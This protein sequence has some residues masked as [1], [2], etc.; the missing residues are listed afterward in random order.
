[1]SNL[2]HALQYA[3]IGLSVIPIS[4]ENKRPLVKWR[5]YQEEQASESQIEEWWTQWPTADVGV[6]TGAVSGIVAVDCDTE[7]AYKEVT[8]RGI[9]SVVGATTKRG[10]HLLFR[11]PG[12]TVR[13]TT[14]WD[15]MENVDVRGDGGYIKVYPSTGYNWSLP[16][17]VDI[18][19][20]MSEMPVWAYGETGRREEI[21]F[22]D[23]ER[24]PIPNEIGAGER[25]DAI[26]RITGAIIKE[27]DDKWGKDILHLVWEE[28]QKRC[29]PPLTK[30]EVITIVRSVSAL[31]K[32]N[33]PNEFNAKGERIKAVRSE[34]EARIEDNRDM[35]TMFNLVS[36]FEMEPR[37][38]TYLV[39]DLIPLGLP[40]VLASPGGVGKTFMLMDLAMKVSLM[41]EEDAPTW[42][43]HRIRKHG[44]SVLFLGEDDALE[45]SRRM[46]SLDPSHRRLFMGEGMTIISIPELPHALTFGVKKYDALE[47]TPEAHAWRE[48]LTSELPEVILG[49]R[50]LALVVIDPLQSFFD[51]RFDEDNIAA[52]RAMK[53]AQSIAVASGASVIFTH[54]LRKDDGGMHV[55]TNPQSAVGKIRGAS[56]VV[57]SARFAIP[58]WRP[59][60]DIAET[61]M[62]KLH[63]V[64]PD[65]FDPSRNNSLFMAG[66]GKENFG[67]DVST[68]WLHRNKDNGLLEDVTH[69]LKEEE[70]RVAD[71]SAGGSVV[72]Y[73]RDKGATSVSDIAE[74]LDIS[75]K[76]VRNQITQLVD[77]SRV[78]KVK[79]GVYDWVGH[80]EEM[81]Q[82][83]MDVYD[84]ARH[85]MASN[86]NHPEFGEDIRKGRLNLRYIG[87][88]MRSDTKALLW[89]EAIRLLV[90]EECMSYEKER[91]S[92]E[93]RDKG[94]RFS[95]FVRLKKAPSALRRNPP[96]SDEAPKPDNPDVDQ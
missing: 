76:T 79:A 88:Y 44:R 2:D 19:H 13:N 28:N 45:V 59:N 32:R 1:M 37:E 54:H 3:E 39:E 86:A 96:S 70:I 68:H 15:G 85:L 23:E 92:G 91:I 63:E 12:Y 27:H 30:E 26:T 90:E 53:W 80:H 6:I 93:R 10:H 52:D 58:I 81:D 33:N 34:A 87:K 77:K 55:P 64:D 51:W 24:D 82:V 9:L 62:A 48:V 47:F 74:A 73:L 14:N 4:A 31:H 71:K 83:R 89:Q 95:T 29:N 8:E 11:H 65:R 36:T 25:N 61:V 17:D 20:M 41:L 66:L 56:N 35:I 18:N 49:Y 78:M 67:G 72:D 38:R 75:E 7:R 42:M 94:G 84:K 60:E 57:N 16:P 5:K 40:G 43:G 46:A 50:D 69:L 22:E 21:N